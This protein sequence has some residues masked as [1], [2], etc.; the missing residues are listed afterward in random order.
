VKQKIT[1]EDIQRFLEFRYSAPHRILGPHYNEEEKSLVIRA[2]FPTR[3]EV[4]IV[5]QKN[6]M[7]FKKQK[8]TKIRDEGLFEIVLSDTSATV[9]YQLEITDKDNKTLTITDPYVFP[10]LMTDF[11]NY[12]F[13]EGNHYEIFKI[14]GAHVITREGV[15]GVNFAFWAPNAQRVS[16]VGTF[17]KWDGRIH[18]MSRQEVTGIWEIFIPELSYG[19]LYKFEVLSP[20]G[21][22]FPKPDP[23]AFAA[24]TYPESASIVYTPEGTYEWKDREW[25]EQCA[26]TGAWELPLSLYELDIR[27]WLEPEDQSQPPLSFNNLVNKVIPYVKEKGHTHIV[28]FPP[29][30]YTSNHSDEA[31]I[32][33]FYTPSSRYGKPEDFMAF[34][35]A[36]HQSGIGVIIDCMPPG[37]LW[38]AHDLVHIDG[39]PVYEKEHH[40]DRVFD[41]EKPSVANFIIANGLY[42][43][44]YF[45]IDGLRLNLPTS[46][47]CHRHFQKGKEILKDMKVI[48]REHD[49]HARI[50]YEEKENLVDG[51]H[52]NPH[53]VLG[54][55][56]IEHENSVIIRALIPHAQQAFILH[57]ERKRIIYEM[58]N[59][60]NGGLFEA[61]IRDQSSF[62]NYRIL[63]ILRDGGVMTISDAY[64]FKSPEF[65]DMDRHLFL[66]GNHYEIYKK[67]GA[68]PVVKDNVYGI[69]F[70]VWAP[71]AERVSVVGSF[72]N[73]DGRLHQ[74]R[75]I[76][77]TGVW[78]IFIPGLGEGDIYKFE[79]RARNGDTFLKI[80]PYA[81]YTEAP[82]KNAS[83]VYDLEGK[84]QWKDEEWIKKRAQTNIWEAPVTIYEVHLGSWMRDTNNN[85]LTYKE[86]TEKLIPY[87]KDMGFTHIEILPIAEHPYDP[88]WGYQ[89]TNY[90]APTSRFGR[91]EELM[92]FIDRCHQ[93][94][95]GVI[96]DWVPAHFPKDAHALARFDGTC[97][98]EHADPRQG[99]H[100]DWGTLI[101]NYG[102]KEIENFLIANALFWLEKYHFDGLRVDAVASM[103]YLDYSKRPGD[104][105]PNKY[106]GN[107][108]L[109]AIDFLKHTNVIVHERVPGVM[110]IAEEST[111]WPAVSQPVSMGGLGFG[112]KWNMGWMHDTLIYIGKDPI[113]R[114]YHH[115]SLTF[116]LVYAFNEKFILP[117]SHDE[118]VH[119]KN[120]LI[121][122][123]PGDDWQ[124]LSNL[125]LLYLYMY[126]H[127]G[128][129]LIF[130]GGEFG[131]WREWDY[132]S[133][134]NWNLLERQSHQGLQ[135]FVQDL[136]A[137]YKSQ[138][139]FYEIDFQHYGFQ[140]IDVNNAE[141][142][143]LG[144]MRK[145]KDARNALFFVLNFSPVPRQYRMGVP[146]PGPYRELLNSDSA[147][148]G[149]SGVV[150]KGGAVEEE[151][152]PWHG[153]PYSVFLEVPPLGG[154]VLK[155]L[156]PKMDDLAIIP[157]QQVTEQVT[158]ESKK[159]VAQKITSYRR[160][161]M[162]KPLEPS[163]KKPKPRKPGWLK[164]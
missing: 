68:H 111:S 24:E 47:L 79:I 85:Y 53:T 148:Y 84:H 163:I 30:Q 18:Q 59:I 42:W 36:C 28:I 126:G 77:H 70:A 10:S 13:S 37:S 114:K 80:D 17:N 11:D 142:N 46:G 123:M 96:L 32:V 147:K 45:H 26:R 122:K 81:F 129:K 5:P 56:R 110:M 48:V 154:L 130:M 131:Q 25:M 83:I 87:V 124:K 132:S 2:F 100:R 136:N 66:E 34:V 103:L 12:L 33:S 41:Y 128:K 98:Y 139:P 160:K 155:A 118:V 144:F 97:L 27:Q 65:K 14:M 150:L 161:P 76:E 109:E 115:H 157:Q 23:Y 149:G 39:T 105:I 21:F 63:L 91:P 61:L 125:R 133:K 95:I 108:N 58:K 52:H 117:L 112:F 138:K 64:A 146:Y 69:N 57:N 60:H 94:G 135:R 119:M 90:F 29:R 113:Y 74:M 92:G 19:E 71:N 31:H 67:L 7:S 49:Y 152:V 121:N 116:S 143:I 55:H 88:S 145:A 44:R 38:Q 51:R 75:I 127:P 120:S 106:G 107:E 72:N 89:V 82:P 16:V 86:L 164:T 137:L 104:W 151:E 20:E 54:P 158:D 162:R 102:R 140:W 4:S 40:N 101:F 35:D 141:E 153:Q 93:E 6:E 62:F 99:E 22:Y 156:P 50:S 15:K 8:M 9:K 1:D 159:T 3:E 43:T 73:W 134:L 78:E